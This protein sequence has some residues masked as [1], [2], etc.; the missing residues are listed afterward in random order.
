MNRM[1]TLSGSVLSKDVKPRASALTAVTD[2]AGVLAV[3]VGGSLFS[4]K[5]VEGSLDLVAIGHYARVIADLHRS[6][7]GRLVFISGG[8][9]IGHAAL[10]DIEDSDPFGCLPLNKALTDVR[11]AWAQALA[12]EGI[13]VLPLQLGA[14]STLSEDGTF[15]VQADTVRKVLEFGALPILS[16]DSVPGHDGSL[17][18]ISSDRVPQFL[19]RALGTPLRVVSL[20]DVPGVLLDGPNGGRTLD[21]INP[22]QPEPAYEALWANSEWDTTG[23][24]RTKVE[25]LVDCA[26]AGVECFI[27]KGST[28]E[29]D[30]QFLFSPHAQWPTRIR[31]TRIALP[32]ER[33]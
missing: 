19:F 3:K 8:G 2:R 27:L 1:E 21:Y 23:G 33:V 29:K 22:F 10:R 32:E 18:G 12:R 9:A 6:N 5:S 14:M 26:S 16:G 17:H 7:T 11:W 4:D 24:F 25:A 30:Y 20:T 15:S 13:K 28:Q 31:R